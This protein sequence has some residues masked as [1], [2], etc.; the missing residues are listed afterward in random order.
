[1]FVTISSDG[2]VFTALPNVELPVSLD[3]I[4]FRCGP[5][6]GAGCP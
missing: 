2:E 5:S 1:M 3:G 4:S 6:G